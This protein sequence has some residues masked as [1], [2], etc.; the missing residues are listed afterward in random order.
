[1]TVTE[2]IHRWLFRRAVR[3]ILQT[4]PVAPGRAAFIALSMVHQRDVLPWLL[5]IKTFAHHAAPQRIVVVADPSLDSADRALM[6]HHV[7]Q[8]EFV[9]A[10]DFRAPGLPVGG[11]WERLSAISVLCAEMPVVQLDADT[12]TFSRPEQVL[13]A[14]ESGRSFVIRSEAGVQLQ[15]LDATAAHGRTLLATSDHIQA[16]AE[17]QMTDLPDWQTR[18][19]VR[20]CSG[21]TGFARGAL[22]PERLADTSL[23]MRSIH[24]ARWDDWGTE[25]VS[26]NLLAASAPG[27]ILLNHPDYCNADS[28]TADSVVVHFIGYARHVN[29]DYER[30]ARAA[31]ALLRR[32]TIA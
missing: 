8:L 26:S 14:V 6:R 15:T 5:A 7:P 13:R 20:G 23:A 32:G 30:L 19:Y 10:A 28:K 29:R 3:G 25:Q 9:E 16:R 22:T 1:M 21:F 31:I 18:L 27:A 17:A 4:P 12:M 11:T 24:G 2:R